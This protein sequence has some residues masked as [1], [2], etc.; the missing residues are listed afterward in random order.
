MGVSMAE[1][2]RLP[3]GYP[4][5]GLVGVDKFSYGAQVSAFQNSRITP[6][7]ESLFLR[8]FCVDARGARG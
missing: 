4:Q 2:A 5:N 7:I 3:T 1:V 8:D 6:V